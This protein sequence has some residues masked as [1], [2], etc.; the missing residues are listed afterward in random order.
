[1]YEDSRD[2]MLRQAKQITDICIRMGLN[3]MRTLAYLADRFGDILFEEQE[4]RES[5]KDMAGV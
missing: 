4:R 5:T 2:H 3:D 1:M